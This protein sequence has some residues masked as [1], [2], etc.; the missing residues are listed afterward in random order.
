MSGREADGAG[1]A[2]Q[3]P[4]REAILTLVGARGTGRTICPSEAARAVS[5]DRWRALMPHVRAEAVRLARD[6]DIAI[7]RK[8]RAVDPDNF[9]GVYRLGLPSAAARG[10]RAKPQ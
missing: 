10:D 6:G 8:G 7:Y 4:V 1:D 2:G 5:A 9:K 3:N